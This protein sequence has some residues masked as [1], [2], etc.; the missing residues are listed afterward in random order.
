MDIHIECRMSKSSELNMHYLP[1]LSCF[2]SVSHL[3]LPSVIVDYAVC[4]YWWQS[5]CC[6]TELET[7]PSCQP[8]VAPWIKST[9]SYSPLHTPPSVFSSL[10][11]TSYYYK[12]K[13][14]KDYTQHEIIQYLSFCVSSK[15]THLAANDQIDFA[16]FK[17]EKYSTA[18]RYHI[19]FTH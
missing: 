4:S 2:L 6:T 3:K 8:D 10:H 5:P 7:Y 14:L 1:Y 17:A 12:F 16:V 15:F 11:S 19:L 9:A 18:Y 13:F